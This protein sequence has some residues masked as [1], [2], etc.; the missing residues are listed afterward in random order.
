MGALYMRCDMPCVLQNFL[1]RAFVKAYFSHFLALDINSD[2]ASRPRYSKIS[3]IVTRSKSGIEPATSHAGSSTFKQ[4]ASTATSRSIAAGETKPRRTSFFIEPKLH[5]EVKE[6]SERHASVI[7]RPARKLS[8]GPP[9]R[10]QAAVRRSQSA[11]PA[12]SKEPG[13]KSATMRSNSPSVV[14]L[15]KVTF[16]SGSKVLPASHVNKATEG[17]IC[18]AGN[19]I[20]P[21]VSKPSEKTRSTVKTGALRKS[22]IP[23]RTNNFIPE[24]IHA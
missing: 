22:M 18:T 12:L 6:G 2:M 14:A 8:Q 1:L 3:N 16:A 5:S 11:E 15:N 21:A 4:N 10:K 7:T 13:K 24:H 23:V 17:A 20:A 9:P 19:G